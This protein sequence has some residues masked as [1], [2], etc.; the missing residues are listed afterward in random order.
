MSK[1]PQFDKALDE[2]FSKLEIDANGGQWRTCRFSGEK[3]YVRPEDIAFYKCIRV[4]LPTLSPHERARRKLAY[5]NIYN[6]FHTKSA[7]S[8]KTIISTYPS[9]TSYKI[10]EHE[11]WNGGG[12]DPEEFAVEYDRDRGF[13]AQY[14]NFQRT[15][16]RPNLFIRNSVESNYTN[17]VSRVKN[18]YLVFDALESEDCGYCIYLD[19]S[20]NCYNSFGPVKSDIC[21]D[22]VLSDNL[23]RAFFVEYSK[24]C[25]DSTFLYDCRDCQYCFA[26][27]NL[28][29]KRYYFLNEQLT[30][31]EYEK[32]IRDINLGDRRVVEE[33]KKKFS[34]LK[35]KA[36]HKANRNERSV[37]CTGDHIKD[38]KDCHTCFFIISGEN[39][40]YSL[41]GNKN[42]DSYDLVGGNGSELSYE[43][44]GL[45]AYNTKFSMNADFL[46]DSEYCDLCENCSDCFACIGLKN[47]SF[48]IFNKQYTEDEYWKLL[49]TIKVKMLADGEYG[50][51]FLP[52]LCPVPYNISLATSFQG[53]D[54]VEN[55]LQYGYRAEELSEGAQNIEGEVINNTDVPE[56]IKNTTDEILEKVI[57]DG[58]NNKKFRYTKKELGF[59]RQYNLALPIEHYS[60]RL[61]RKRIEMGPI[62]FNIKTRRCSR[63]GEKTQVSFPENHPDAPRI[64]YCEKCYNEAVV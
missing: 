46:R 56:D 2:Y 35:K 39:I 38:S 40:A 13:F 4:P 53:Y 25:I 54:D 18:C 61:A 55:A 33:W 16:P 45:N 20:K 58:K 21:H 14:H 50:E 49:D 24:D 29:H 8:G 3:F 12:W 44:W 23:Y 27:T 5:A 62:D 26:S 41:G 43:T 47:R 30:K 28:R 15:V 7:L 10:Y 60:I 31:E 36:I 51:F 9:S 63:C 42:R 32:K 11:I 34:E 48:C 37:N 22:C 6:L 52:E 1:T 59:H 64:V 57:F 17:Y 19:H